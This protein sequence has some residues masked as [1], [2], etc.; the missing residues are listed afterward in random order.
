MASLG[1][2]LYVFNIYL[3]KLFELLSDVSD[4]G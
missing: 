3:E 2:L 4:G 1:G